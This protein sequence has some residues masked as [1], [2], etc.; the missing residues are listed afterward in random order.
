MGT[1]EQKPTIL[2]RYALFNAE[3]ERREQTLLQEEDPF[4][5]DPQFQHV[6]SVKSVL[7]EAVRRLKDFFVNVQVDPLRAMDTNKLA[8]MVVVEELL[9]RFEK[10]MDRGQESQKFIMDLF[11]YSKHEVMSGYCA[12]HNSTSPI[13]NMF[14]V[15]RN[16]FFCGIIKT[17]NSS[18]VY[19]AVRKEREAKR[20]DEAA[21]KK[22]GKRNVKA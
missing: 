16:N 13:D 15:M 19:E 8:K 17:I 11:E 4:S 3:F 10:F 18:V 22:S 14:S 9:Y 2:E 21:A 12:N 7:D 6:R 5:S 20:A 1:P